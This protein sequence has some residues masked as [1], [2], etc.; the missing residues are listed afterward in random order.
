MAGATVYTTLEPCTTRNHP[1]IPCAARLIERKVARVVIGMLDPDERITGRGWR[2]LRTAGIVVESFPP[3]LV[4]E[5]EELNREFTR[6]CEQQSQTQQTTKPSAEKLQIVFKGD[7]KPYLAEMPKA[8]L[9]GGLLVDRRYRVGIWNTGNVVISKARVVLENCEP[10]AHHGI[11]PGHALQL[12]GAP[13]GTG[14]FSV[15]PGDVPSA[16]V[17]VIYDETPAG[18]PLRDDPGRPCA[19]PDPSDLRF[20]ET[21]IS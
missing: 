1:K 17:D 3:D 6:F 19:A 9:P 10:S 14:E 5:I 12:M 4:P 2:K 15:Q 8:T 20:R 7:R 18:T 13:P 16:F 11:H 21:P